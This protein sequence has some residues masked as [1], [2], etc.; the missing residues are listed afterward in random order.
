MAQ[1]TGQRK[2]AQPVLSPRPTATKRR[3][4]ARLV[5][6][7]PAGY[8]R[9]LSELEMLMHYPLRDGLDGASLLQPRHRT[10]SL[11]EARR[12]V[13]KQEIAWLRSRSGSR[14]AKPQ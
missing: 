10:E 12:D 6:K 3:R 7:H 4:T 14:I 9:T 1:R 5:P 8:D 11:E 2:K 13:F